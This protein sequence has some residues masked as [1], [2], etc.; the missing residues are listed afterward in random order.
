MSLLKIIVSKQLVEEHCKTGFSI[1]SLTVTK[2]LP[3]DAQFRYAAVDES[4][5]LVLHFVSKKDTG[6]D[7][8]VYLEVTT[9]SYV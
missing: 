8:T 1:R 3:D 6:D 4:G 5:A 7:R 2:G 9:H